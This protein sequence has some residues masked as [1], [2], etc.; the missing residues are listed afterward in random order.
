MGSRKRESDVPEEHEQVLQHDLDRLRGSH[1]ERG[2]GG[3]PTRTKKKSCGFKGLLSMQALP[4]V[5]EDAHQ[6][7]ASREKSN[8]QFYH[9]ED[10]RSSVRRSN[11]A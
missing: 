5:R 11:A 7:D 3:E 2:E 6:L 1:G 9:K 10:S 4:K 8:L